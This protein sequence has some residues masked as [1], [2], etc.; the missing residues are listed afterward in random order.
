MTVVEKVRIGSDHIPMFLI[1][2]ESRADKAGLAILELLGWG[3][4]KSTKQRRLSPRPACRGYVEVYFDLW[5]HGE[6]SEPD[7]AARCTD[8]F[9]KMAMY[10]LRRTAEDAKAVV[11]Y[12]KE[13]KD[14]GIT[15]IGL[16]GYSIGGSIAIIALTLDERIDAAVAVNGFLVCDYLNEYLNR[17]CA[18]PQESTTDKESL[19]DED[20]KT[21]CVQY[22]PLLHAEKFRKRPVMLFCNVDDQIANPEGTRKL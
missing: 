1:Y 10:V 16:V 4:A 5:G 12:L 11:S 9:L 18:R 17:D 15:R 14:L 21:Q 19:V 20:L 13:R 3:E 2:E 7:F 8:N 6:R 22:D